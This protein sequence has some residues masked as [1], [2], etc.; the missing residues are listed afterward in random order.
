MNKL[1]KIEYLENTECP[2]CGGPPVQID[3]LTRGAYQFHN[4]VIP[5]P[6]YGSNTVPI[7]EC[8]ECGLIFKRFIP[9]KKALT[10]VFNYCSSKIWKTNRY[11][12][13]EK[14][15]ILGAIT[16]KNFDIIDIGSSDCGVLQSLDANNG[17]K[18]ALDL[19]VNRRC[20]KIVTGE[21]INSLIEDELKWSN[22][23]YDL[24][25][26]FDIFEHFYDANKAIANIT[27]L[28]KEGGL[29][30]IH[31][32]DPEY[33]KGSYNNW[34]YINYFEHHII[35]PKR[36]IKYIAN[37]YGYRVETLVNCVH[38]GRENLTQWKRIILLL[39]H[40]TRHIGPIRLLV[41]K[42]LGM[43][44]RL[45]GNPFVKDHMTVIMKKMYE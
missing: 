40:L 15:I 13:T 34:W 30:I 3:C 39:M 10:N 11:P 41:F 35:W 20:K 9:T 33:A 1:V 43:D 25:T 8:K 28:L 21:Y 18:S 24:L 36:T 5:Y 37:K 4:L 26:A 7:M 31:T 19:S 29:A 22:R 12:K 32:G 27:S 42:T 38:K 14:E 16:K 6:E 2:L 17:R 44:T 23:P 45:I